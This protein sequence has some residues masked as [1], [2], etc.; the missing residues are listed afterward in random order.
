MIGNSSKALAALGDF[1][2]ARVF[3]N[4]STATATNASNLTVTAVGNNV[5]Q[6]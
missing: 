5:H 2:T 3:G 1:N 6:P 4:G